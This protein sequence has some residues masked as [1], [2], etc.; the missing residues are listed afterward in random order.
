MLTMV[1][2]IILVSIGGCL[3]IVVV[4]SGLRS[5]AWQTGTAWRT[6][7]RWRLLRE[8]SVTKSTKQP[9]EFLGGAVKSGITKANLPLEKIN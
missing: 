7:W 9:K 2:T 6:S 1:G 5:Q 4:V 8:S 3:C